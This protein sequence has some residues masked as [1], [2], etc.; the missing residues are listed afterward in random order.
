M[1]KADRATGLAAQAWHE[2]VSEAGLA[3]IGE[4]LYTV[5]PFEIALIHMFSCGLVYGCGP[6]L[7]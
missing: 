1:A 6:G 7:T 3:L 2:D 5:Q 4:V